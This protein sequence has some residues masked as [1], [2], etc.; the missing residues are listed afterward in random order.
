MVK[1]ASSDDPILR[2]PG[3]P[4]DSFPVDQGLISGMFDLMIKFDGWGLAANQVGVSLNLFV[5]GT[6]DFKKVFVNPKITKFGLRT[7][8]FEERCLSSPGISVKITRPRNIQ[9]EYQDEN[10]LHHKGSFDGIISRIIQHEY[11]HCLGRLIT[12]YLPNAKN[13]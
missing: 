3:L 7:I 10:G 6:P 1:L 5:V 11:E 9:I 13:E 4:V 2:T 8:E 12:D